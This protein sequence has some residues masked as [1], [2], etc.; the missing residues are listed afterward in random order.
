[1]RHVVNGVTKNSTVLPQGATTHTI[2]SVPEGVSTINVDFLVNGA[3]GNT[4]SITLRVDTAQPQF[5]SLEEVPRPSP[6]SG[7]V[8]LAVKAED[9]LS[10]LDHYAFTIDGATV[11]WRDDGTG[12]FETI[13][14]PGTY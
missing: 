3:W 13:L 10:G 7:R 14:A 4:R 12:V 5:I 2:A 1:V 8:H 9:I 6:T 11:E